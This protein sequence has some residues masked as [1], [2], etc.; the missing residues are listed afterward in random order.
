MSRQDEAL[1]NDVRM[2]GDS[3]GQTIAHHLGPDFLAKIERI[4]HLAKTGRSDADSHHADL[5]TELIDLSEADV[6][7]VARAFTQF[8]NLAN[9]AEEF[10][11]VRL[12]K[13]A[14]EQ[15]SEGS[16]VQQLERLLASGKSPQQITAAIL[17]MKVD[18]VLTAHPTE[19]N[20]RT[21]IGKYNAITE[22]LRRLE[23]GEPRTPRVNELVSQ[24]WHTSEIRQQRPTPIDEAKWGFA[25]IESSLWQ[26]VP[27]YLRQLDE[28]MRSRLGQSLPLDFSPV[29]FSSW[30]GGDRD[31]NPY[32]TAPVTRE[33]LMLSRWMAADLYDRDL[34][35]LRAELSMHKC[36]A[37][38]RARVGDAAEPYRYLLTSLRQRLKATK[39][40]VRRI[41]AG[42][43]TDTSQLLTKDELLEPLLLCHRSLNE[44]GMAIIAGGLLEDVIR[45]VACF[46]DALVRLDIRQNADRHAAVLDALTQPH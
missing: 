2:L 1:R 18:L 7:P 6:L 3:L 9:I 20:R 24:I 27:N 29:R 25:V 11:R 37:E 26:A 21:L 13:D 33:V 5:L 32:V 42:T 14:D 4:R 35:S 15:D 28:Q 31:G 41:L 34:D 17:Q 22:C 12:Y 10:H 8:L 45:R 44:C 43:A 23:L 30:M 36:N 46:G 19:V 16:F 39:K 40:Q 38:L